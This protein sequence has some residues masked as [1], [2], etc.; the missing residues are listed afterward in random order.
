[1]A[2]PE[3]FGHALIDHGVQLVRFDHRDVGLS[4]QLTD[5]PSPDLPAVLAG[6]LSWVSYTLSDMAADA[7]GLPVKLRLKPSR[8]TRMVV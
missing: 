7:V 3:A 1:V 8:R 4:T 2:W 6:D 5:A